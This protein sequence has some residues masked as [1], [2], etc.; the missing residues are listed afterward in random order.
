MSPTLNLIMKTKMNIRVLT[1]TFLFTLL[2]SI[3]VMAI[4]NTEKDA[5]IKGYG[6]ESYD[7]LEEKIKVYIDGGFLDM[8]FLRRNMR[9]ADFV[10]D[11]KVADVQ[12]IVTNQMS[13]SGGMVYS[14]RYNNVTLE[15]FENFTITCTTSSSDTSDERRQKL[16]DALSMGLMPFVN[17]TTVAEK[18][19]LNYDGGMERAEPVR[20]VDDKWNNW[21]F[22]GD[23]SGRGKFEESREN[24]N[25]SFRVNADKVTDEWKLRNRASRSVR[26]SKNTF[27][28]DG[29]DTEYKSENTTNSLSTSAVKSLTSR[30]SVGLFA[31]YENSNYDNTVYDITLKPAIEY[32]IFPWDASDRKVFTFS[33]HIG[34]VWMK[35]YE[36]TIYDKMKENLWE[37]TLRLNL[38]IVQPWG[39]VEAS[40]DATNY[41]RDWSQNRITFDTSLSIRIVRGL[42]IR[43]GFQIENIHDQI[44]LAKGDLS[45]EDV[46]LNNVQLPSTFSFSPNL[47]IQIQFGSIYNN[48]VNNRLGGGGG[49]FR[50]GGGGFF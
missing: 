2:T 34:H 6:A 46:L 25:Y 36:E 21:T 35:Y 1:I 12:I 19:V 8:D 43:T 33:Y 11:P 29:V 9:F 20:K 28:M 17:Q 26:I 31:D 18:L 3:N 5:V 7:K 16:R 42:S 27:T 41:M 37:Q 24:Y 10:N 49:G 30:W 48:V 39:E 23:V 47:G 14:L 4:D 22:K 45:L 44:Y 32:N 50:G 15:N 13:G 40:L 38:E